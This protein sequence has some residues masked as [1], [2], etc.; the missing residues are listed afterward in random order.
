VPLFF[1]FSGIGHARGAITLMNILFLAECFEMHLQK[2][3]RLDSSV[4]AKYCRDLEAFI[5]WYLKPNQKPDLTTIAKVKQKDIE[6]YLTTRRNSG[7]KKER[8]FALD[9][10]FRFLVHNELIM[11]N[12]MDNIDQDKWI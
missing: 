9:N 6:S 2:L 3:M 5:Q 4:T 11:S 12:P 10:Y 7:N 8:F 1:H